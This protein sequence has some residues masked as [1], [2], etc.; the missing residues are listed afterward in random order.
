MSDDF[1]NIMSRSNIRIFYIS[2]Q[3]T[4]YKNMEKMSIAM[5]LYIAKLTELNSFPKSK[6]IGLM[7]TQ[8]LNDREGDP[9]YNPSHEEQMIYFIMENGNRDLRQFSIEATEFYSRESIMHAE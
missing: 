8:T 1:K 4:Y 5:N 6:Y 7:S 2:D 9:T 3:N